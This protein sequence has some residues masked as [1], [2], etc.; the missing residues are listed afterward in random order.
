[1][2]NETSRVPINGAALTQTWEAFTDEQRQTCVIIADVFEP[3]AFIMPP[4]KRGHFTEA[5]ATL[6]LAH[7]IRW[8]AF[9]TAPDVT[10]DGTTRDV[11]RV[12][13]DGNPR[14]RRLSDLHAN[15]L[16]IWLNT[17]DDE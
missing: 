11:T 12:I 6:A 3:V 8:T 15:R 17:P 1:M 9:I 10:W 13:N 14:L 5:M 2:S 16:L 4:D 7:A